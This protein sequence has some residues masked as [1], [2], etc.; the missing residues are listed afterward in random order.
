MIGDGGESGEI[1]PGKSL[2]FAGLEVCLCILV[3]HMPALNP[4]LPPT[5]QLSTKQSSTTSDSAIQLLSGTLHTMAELPSLCSP[6]GLF[7]L[8]YDLCEWISFFLF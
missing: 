2:A 6:A 4:S 7:F 8:K 1:I 3:R 5:S